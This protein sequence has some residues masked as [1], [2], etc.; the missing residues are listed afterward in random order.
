MEKKHPKRKRDKYNPY[1]IYEK[2]G[3][4]YI[5]FEDGQAVRHN[6]E[7]SR[8][9]FEAFNSFELEDIKYLNV[10]S[11]HLE[12]SEIWKSTLNSRALERPESVEDIVLKNIQMEQLHKVIDSLPEKQKQRLILHYF[13]QQTYVEIAKREGCS[14]RAIEYSIAKAIQKIKKYFEKN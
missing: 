14:T 12:H 10:L 3:S 13:E 6:F 9:L 8:E 4:T 1:T 7:I 2:D 11:R 5:T